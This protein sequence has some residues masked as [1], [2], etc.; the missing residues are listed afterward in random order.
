MSVLLGIDIGTSSCKAMMLDID[1]GI[2]NVKAINYDVDIPRE[3]YAEQN[4]D[5]W[6]SS[7]VK[8]L[9]QMK[10]E[11][12]DAFADIAGISYSGQMHGMVVV[13]EAGEPLRP[14]IIWL[15]QRSQHQL[16]EIHDQYG[17]DKIGDIIHNRIFTGFAFPS[18]LWM[19]ENE[20]EIFG[21]IHKM[22]LPKDFIRY[23][24]TGKF[25]TDTSDASSTTC[26]DLRKRDWAWDLIDTFGMPRD[27]FPQC[28]EATEIAG[29]IT[30]ECAAETGL[31]EGIPVSYGCGDQPAHVIG[32]GV[33]KA[34]T[35]VSNIGTGGE[36]SVYS[37]T[38]KYD[39]QMRIHTFC[40]AV[41]NAYMVF[42][43][44][45][46]SGMSLKW[47][48]D[49]VLEIDDFDRMG[50]LTDEV[51]AGCEGLIYL[52]YLTGSR[53]PEMDVSAKG[54][55]FGLQ[56]KHDK[57]H[58]IR[59]VMEGII[60]DFKRSLD[61]FQEIGINSNKV[62]A[63]GGGAKS[64][65]WLQIQ[66]DIL[67]R[68]VQV[69]KVKEQACLGACI[70]AGLS[71]NIFDNVK[72]ACDKYVEM[73]SKIYQPDPKTAKVYEQNYKVYQQLYGANKELFIS[74]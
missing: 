21:R 41:N 62:I 69:C 36:M 33:I 73:E 66:A 29:Y 60:Y 9:K 35:I 47:L 1:K 39:S 27:I 13:D 72:T 45:L 68:E 42:G 20:P 19:K 55:F 11:H 8:I 63:C 25:G 58:F 6:W 24:M 67:N 26:L 61:I 70:I 43:A 64:T 54:I 15:D 10:A 50:K 46:C 18:L 52:P 44:H 57:R 48:K 14:S 59:A 22:L 49:R 2:I 51:P 56:L 17:L 71:T 28:H 30:R 65:Q 32:A 5:V 53:T 34:G 40:H 3:G 12:Q 74:A 31:K 4:A 37:D 23:K 38:D 16:E 7:L